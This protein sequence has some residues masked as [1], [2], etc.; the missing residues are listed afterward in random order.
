[1]V[2]SLLRP[3]DRATIVPIPDH[4]SWTAAALAEACPAWAGALRA[5]GSLAEGLAWLME[6]EERPPGASRPGPLPVVAGSLHLL[7]ALLPLL[8]PPQPEVGAST[9][10]G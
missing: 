4:R 5:A 2:A 3:G 1:M 10:P 8:D 6:A 7:G 9:P